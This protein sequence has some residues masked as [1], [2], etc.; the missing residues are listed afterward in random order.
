MPLIQYAENICEID[1]DVHRLGLL[2]M[3]DEKHQVIIT[4]C[5]FCP[6]CL[7]VSGLPQVIAAL[8][9]RRLC[10]VMKFAYE[11]TLQA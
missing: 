5:Q 11:K 8:Y 1:V 9:K 3:K 10:S 6:I 7:T 4:D 2:E